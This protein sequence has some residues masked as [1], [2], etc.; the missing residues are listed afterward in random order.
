MR[1]FRKAESENSL[2]PRQCAAVLMYNGMY[3]DDRRGISKEINLLFI[4]AWPA[5][6]IMCV[7]GEAAVIDSV[8]LEKKGDGD[9]DVDGGVSDS[10]TRR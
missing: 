6:R 7:D 8:V 1:W 4:S 2:S 5:C 9:S 3:G 10:V